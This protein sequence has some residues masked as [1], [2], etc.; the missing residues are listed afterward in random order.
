MIDP[1]LAPDPS[2]IRRL[3]AFLVREAD[4]KVRRVIYLNRRA[5]IVEN[6][7]TGQAIHVAIL[8]A[9]IHHEMAHLRGQGENEARRSEREFFQRLVF[10]GNVPVDE[11][12]RYLA[13][14]EQDRQ[15][16]EG[17]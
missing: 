7:L 3:D 9:V 10:D 15:L 14:L 8:A 11:G 5:T 2:A 13:A 12:L 4:G 1:E 6:A 16:G 17:R